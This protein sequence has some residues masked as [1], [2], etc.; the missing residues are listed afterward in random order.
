ME[1]V[2][3]AEQAGYEALFVPESSG[4][5]AFSTLSGLSGHTDALLLGTGIVTIVARRLST[6]AMAA[7]TLYEISGGRLVLGLGTGPVG[8]G[9]LDRLR[10]Y[11]TLLRSALAGEEVET[12]ENGRFRLSFHPGRAVP[13]WLAALN[14]EALELVRRTELAERLGRERMYFTVEDAVAAFEK[15]QTR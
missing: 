1:I 8:P 6:T 15:G 2:Q 3:T 11:V 7:A 5:E 4:R 9:V 12:P 13:I 14:P 10:E